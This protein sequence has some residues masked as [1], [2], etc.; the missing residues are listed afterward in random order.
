MKLISFYCDIDGSTFYSDC[1]LQLINQCKYFN[2]EYDIRNEK[3]S[4]EWIKNVQYKPTF[5]LKLLMELNED[6]LW[7]DIDCNIHK[8][9]NFNPNSD[10]LVDFR[11]NLYPY[12]YV[13]YIKN[14]SKNKK[15][16]ELWID[17]IC[18]ANKGDHSAF[19]SVH[20]SINPTQ[21]PI[22]YFTFNLSTGKSK[23]NYFNI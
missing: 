4:T 8:K 21:I 6:I 16:I 18:T 1:S 11:D 9:L 17:E 23:N 7:L 19:I 2:I 14:T 22:G 15:F 12:S 20:K 10:W 5:I 3:I 13:H